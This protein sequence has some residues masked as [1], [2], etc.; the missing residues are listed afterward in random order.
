MNSP[1]F[2]TIARVEAAK[3]YANP[4]REKVRM[5][6]LAGAHLS[7]ARRGTG[8]GV[9]LIQGVGAIGAAWQ[10]QIED[11]S[12]RHSTVA[13]DNRGI[14]GSVNLG[15]PLT[16]EAM[17]EDALAV[18]DAEEL[19]RFHVVGHSMGGLIA[20]EVALRAPRRVKSLSL[21]CTFAR[22]AQ[23]ARMTPAM[24]LAGLRTRVGTRAMRRK[25]FLELVVPPEILAARGAAP[26]A[27]DLGRL[28][29]RDL[30]DQPPIIMKQ[31]R[32]MGRYDVGHRLASLG[33]I[34]TLVA[35]CELDRIALPAF[36]RELAAAIPG[37]RFVVLRGAGHGVPLLDPASINH[38]LR[39][40]LASADR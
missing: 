30:A 22:G 28:F 16:I 12:R 31:V 9:L 32:A 25:A 29:A 27:E 13:F 36:G 19:D 17:A 34:P 21:L 24:I 6:E 26:L 8:T 4:V 20:Q 14:G 35:S 40:H 2:E 38:L 10:P 1:P 33:A 18:M 39:S 5:L 23:G 3:P 7:Y 37:A 11:L 15:G